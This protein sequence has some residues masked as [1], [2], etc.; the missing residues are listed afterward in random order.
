ME[1]F[2]KEQIVPDVISSIPGAQLKVGASK[3]FIGVSCKVKKNVRLFVFFCNLA[4]LL[5]ETHR[6]KKYFCLQMLIHF[7]RYNGM[8]RTWNRE[9]NGHRLKSKTN[10]L[11]IGRLMRVHFTLWS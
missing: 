2:T 1:N 10:H 9:R 7:E 6:V 5:C 4:V 11:F 8:E 3:L